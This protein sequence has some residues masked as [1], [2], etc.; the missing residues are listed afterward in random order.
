[1]DLEE[2]ANDT[3]RRSSTRP[4]YDARKTER[5]ATSPASAREIAACVLGDE[6]LST[7]EYVGLVPLDLTPRLVVSAEDL[8]WF[9]LTPLGRMLVARIDGVSTLRAI[10]PPSLSHADGVREI[11]ALV[12]QG[13]LQFR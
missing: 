9:E 1:V 4:R 13:I 8:T 10:L 2:L 11:C 7:G 3:D 12:E 5:P 6:K